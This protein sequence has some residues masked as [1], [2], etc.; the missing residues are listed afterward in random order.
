MITKI[1]YKKSLYITP[2]YLDHKCLIYNGRALE[3]LIISKDMIGYKFG[4]FINTR[5][6]IK[7]NK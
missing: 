4:E 6:I 2:K 3:K 1:I 7:Y 5:R